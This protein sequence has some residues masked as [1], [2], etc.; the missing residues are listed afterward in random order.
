MV[1]LY[2]NK[3]ALPPSFVLEFKQSSHPQLNLCL[4][5]NNTAAI[6]KLLPPIGRVDEVKAWEGEEGTGGGGKDEEG[7]GGGEKTRREPAEG[8]KMRRTGAS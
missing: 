1:F 8:E 5:S 6:P 7:T 4:I 2:I 3:H